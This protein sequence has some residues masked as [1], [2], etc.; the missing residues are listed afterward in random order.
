MTAIARYILLSVFAWSC[1]T[2]C[3]HPRPA[4]A[5]LTSSD[6]N[7]I[8]KQ[9]AERSGIDLSD[10]KRPE[11]R[12]RPDGSWFVFFDGHGLSRTVGSHFAVVVDD[13]TGEAR[14]SPG[15]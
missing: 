2:G 5:R 4:G 6:V 1:L 14:V 8:A 9:A 7:R 3:A 12:Y 13:R 10:Y 11:A 15:M